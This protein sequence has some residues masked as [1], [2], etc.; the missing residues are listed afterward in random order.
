MIFQAVLCGSS[1]HPEKPRVWNIPVFFEVGCYLWDT[2]KF[3]DF[4]DLF[5]AGQ[6][7][8]HGTDLGGDSAVRKEIS[9][10]A[11]LLSAFKEPVE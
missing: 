10:I 9:H 6:L 11:S 3:Q 7:A 1:S 8:L 4:T 5:F 2:G